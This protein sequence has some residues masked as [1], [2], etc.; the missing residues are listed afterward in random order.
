MDSLVVGTFVTLDGVM[1]VP[2]GP[3]ED[4]RG[5]FTHGDWSVGYWGVAMRELHHEG[6]RT[7]RCA[8]PWTDDVQDLRGALAARPQRRSG[9]SSAQSRVINQYRRAGDIRYGSFVVDERGWVEALWTEG[10]ERR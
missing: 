6:D 1:Q 4:R 9:R 10:K 2:G 7:G 3:D 5:G 8:P